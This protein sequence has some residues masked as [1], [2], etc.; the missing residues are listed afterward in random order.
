MPLS[1]RAGSYFPS[2]FRI[3]LCIFPAIA[4]FACSGPSPEKL[5]AERVLRAIDSLR[6]A[7]S[8]PL[9]PRIQL[10]NSLKKEPT[11]TQEATRARDACVKAYS[12]MLEGQT[13]KSKVKEALSDPK[14]LSPAI[15]LDLSEAEAQIKQSIDAM[16]ECSEAT[17]QLRRPK[18]H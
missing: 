3:T 16:P 13:L 17:F 5:E 14:K 10:L 11:Q 9:E 4:L 1:E 6:N 8:E 7:P 2:H 12:H 18:E 15:A